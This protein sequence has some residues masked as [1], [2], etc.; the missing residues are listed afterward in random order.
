MTADREAL[1][2]LYDATRGATCW[3]SNTNWD[4]ANALG[5]WEG[6]TTNAAGRVTHIELRENQ[7]TGPLP[8]EMGVLSSLEELWLNKNQLSGPIPRRSAT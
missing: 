8:D 4:S 5:D 1:L 2:A 3:A 7:L 6:V